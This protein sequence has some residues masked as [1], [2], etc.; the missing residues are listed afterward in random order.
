[1]N[2]Q[3]KKEITLFGKSKKSSRTG[4]LQLGFEVLKR[5][6]EKQMNVPGRKSNMI[7]IME[8]RKCLTG[9]GYTKSSCQLLMK[10]LKQVTGLDSQVI[11]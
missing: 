10:I 8:T 4:A 5:L 1:M 9:T 2:V 3:R 7:K 11:G 6:T